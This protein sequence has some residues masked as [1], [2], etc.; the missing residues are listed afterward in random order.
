[1]GAFPLY[2]ADVDSLVNKAK[3]NAVLS[4]QTDQEIH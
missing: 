4:L 1:M 3:V 2:K